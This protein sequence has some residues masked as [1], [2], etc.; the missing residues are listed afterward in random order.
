[1]AK[2]KNRRPYGDHSWTIS[3]CRRNPAQVHGSGED[4]QEGLGVEREPR[5]RYEVFS[6]Q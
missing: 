6:W 3:L 1:M 5:Q 4:A 2:S